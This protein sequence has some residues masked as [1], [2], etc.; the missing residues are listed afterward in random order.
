VLGQAFAQALY[1]GDE[2]VDPRDYNKRFFNDTFKKQI[3][4]L[5]QTNLI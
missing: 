1:Q 5:A 4:P 3:S 2:R